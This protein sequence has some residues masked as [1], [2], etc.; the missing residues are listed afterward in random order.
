MR[1][2]ALLPHGTARL[3]AIAR[4][5]VYEL[6]DARRRRLVREAEVGEILNQLRFDLAMLYSS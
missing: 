6:A 2:A 3:D 4:S 1:R 5:L